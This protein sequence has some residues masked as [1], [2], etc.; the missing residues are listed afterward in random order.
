MSALVKR[1]CA[2][3]S[4]AALAA[5]AVVAC[6]GQ[7][8]GGGEVSGTASASN[9]APGSA[10]PSGS[11]ET[12]GAAA[13]AGYSDLPVTVDGV[14]TG[15]A[16]GD[17]GVFAIDYGEGN[18]LD[19]EFSSVSA[20][21]GRL[22]LVP[23]DG[24]AQKV[25]AEGVGALTGVAVAP[26]GAVYVVDQLGSRVLRFEKG[27][28]APVPVPFE[29]D[30]PERVA[31]TAAGDVVVLTDDGVEVLPK[32]ATT[33]T[34]IEAFFSSGDAM[35]VSP[36][37]AI[38]FT[39]TWDTLFKVD[40]G[41][42]EAREL[43]DPEVDP[44]TVAMAFD[45]EGNR[46]AIERTSTKEVSDDGLHRCTTYVHTLKKFEGDTETSTVVP[47]E[48]LK[49]TLPTALSITADAMYISDGSRVVKAPRP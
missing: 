49:L 9:S 37:G 39:D 13:P 34:A 15:V 17:E 40:K 38:Y 32:G 44:T 12:T 10:G 42:T 24:S 6:G 23:P 28:G 25:V 31:V 1:M 41:A 22:L 4:M 29:S 21:S 3:I 19:I 8:S 16:V 36:D 46:Y 5:S 26:D 43:Y 7:G 27:S 20:D 2:T 45:P 30:D 33:P 11:S 35:A 18:E 14:A 48:G 47:I